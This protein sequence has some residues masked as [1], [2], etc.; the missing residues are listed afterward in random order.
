MDNK[1]RREIAPSNIA[2]VVPVMFLSKGFNRLG[3]M[4]Y[5]YDQDEPVFSPQS[6]E[7][8]KEIINWKPR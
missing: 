7:E 6:P 4:L 8:I 5:L 3:S 1:Y 2:V